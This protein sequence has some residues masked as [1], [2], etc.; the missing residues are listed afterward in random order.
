MKFPIFGKKV[1]KSFTF[2]N[3]N[4]DNYPTNFI[5]LN[6]FS[7]TSK[8]N[9]DCRTIEG[10]RDAYLY[11][12]AVT[13][14]VNYKVAA[15]SNARFVFKNSKGDETISRFQYLLAKPNS[16]QTWSQF[17]QF[18]KTLQQIHG[19]A[20]IYVRNLPGIKQPELFI[21]P[22]WELIP[23]TSTSDFWGESILYYTWTRFSTGKSITIY[24]N[25][26]LIMSDT[27]Q[28]LGSATGNYSDGGSRLVSLSDAVKNIVSAYEARGTILT[29]GGPPVIVSPEKDAL[30]N[31]IMMDKD[32]TDL[33]NKLSNRYG[34][35]LGKKL[36]AI[37]SQPLK[38]LKI[39]LN[40]NDLSAFEEVKND[41]GEICR[42]YGGGLSYIFGIETTT[43]NN[44][45]EAKKTFYQDTVI[46]ET[47]SDLNQIGSFLGS[48]ETFTCDFS[49][50][51]VLQKSENDKIDTFAKL[52]AALKPAIE[53][54]IYTA[55]EAKDIIN[56]NINLEL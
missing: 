51:E 26:M 49:H 47:T 50:V 17:W 37:A 46:P 11:C 38:M 53:A 23:Q 40:P 31:S 36:I 54:G 10:Q 24:P 4:F 56:R 20:Y 29:N 12:P 39:G 41:W 48:P 43:F 7:N 19:R 14:I 33:E 55:A 21:V 2:T 44:L 18:A 45:S 28:D 42:A 5:P 15:S 32:K 3:R 35:Q 13:A 6:F 9:F 8:T 34:Y 27:G 25:E 52:T 30:G 22:N 1:Q 16:K